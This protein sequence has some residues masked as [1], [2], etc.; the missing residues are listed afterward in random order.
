LQIFYRAANLVM[1]ETTKIWILAYRM[2][3]LWGAHSEKTLMD[4]IISHHQ[5]PRSN[6]ERGRQKTT[7]SLKGLKERERIPKKD[8]NVRVLKNSYS[9]VKFSRTVVSIFVKSCCLKVN[10]KAA[11]GGKS[12]KS[13]RSPTNLTWNIAK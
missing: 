10:F 12:R 2:K 5:H 1:M 13:K 9:S 7:P 8:S 6:K 11:A 4:T 3:N